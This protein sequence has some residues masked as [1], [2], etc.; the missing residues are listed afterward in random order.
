MAVIINGLVT[1]WTLPEPKVVVNDRRILGVKPVWDGPHQP[2]QKKAAAS[3][4]A[5]VLGG[6][7]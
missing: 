1:L 6:L 3:G 2:W 4:E 5:F 7:F